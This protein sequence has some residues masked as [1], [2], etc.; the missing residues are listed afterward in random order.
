MERKEGQ[1]RQ[2]KGGKVEEEKTRLLD[3]E[4]AQT[5]REKNRGNKIVKNEGREKKGEG[6]S[7]ARARG[8]RKRE[9]EEEADCG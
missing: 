7:R 1:R 9:E 4:A 8:R 5:N 3:Q 2:G 6:E